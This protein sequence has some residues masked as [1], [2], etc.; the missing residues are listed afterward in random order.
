MALRATQA[1]P[2]EGRPG[3]RQA[4]GMKLAGCSGAPPPDTALGTTGTEPG[5]H[6]AAGSPRP[7]TVSAGQ[8]LPISRRS[9]CGSS[10]LPLPAQAPA[11]NFPELDV[12]QDYW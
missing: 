6:D 3:R 2:H 7:T 12:S 1:R 9:R 4:R 10:S 11:S 8:R 5:R